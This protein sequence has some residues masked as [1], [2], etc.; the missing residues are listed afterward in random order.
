VQVVLIHLLCKLVEGRLTSGTAAP[1]A[2][3]GPH[4]S[5]RRR[6]RRGRRSREHEAA[7]RDGDK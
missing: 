5:P 4:G 7:A 2:L 6:G 1:A 3:A